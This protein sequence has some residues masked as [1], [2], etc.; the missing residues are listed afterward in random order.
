MNEYQTAIRTVDLERDRHVRLPSLVVCK[1]LV[2]SGIW[3]VQL[4]YGQTPVGVN[5]VSAQRT[6][7]RITAIENKQYKRYIKKYCNKNSI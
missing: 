7:L 5:G 3:Q 1:A 2:F 4:N 6:K